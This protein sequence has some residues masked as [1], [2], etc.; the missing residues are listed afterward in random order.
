[1]H[2]ADM[3]LGLFP[4]WFGPPQPDWPAN[5]R[6]VG[7]PLWDAHEAAELPGDVREFLAAGDAPIAFSPGSANRA[8]HQFFEAAV[9]ACQRL[10]RRGTLDDEIRR[11]IAGDAAA[12]SAA[13]R[14]RAAQPVAAPHGGAGPSRRHR[15]LRQGL[16]AG[17]PQL[18]RP[19]A[20]DQ[21]D[22]SRRLAALGVAEE[23][24][25]KAFHGPAIAA[26]LERLLAS[27]RVETEMRGTGRPLQRRGLAR[28]GM[29]CAG[30]FGAGCRGGV[31]SADCSPQSVADRG[32]PAA[33]GAWLGAGGGRGGGDRAGGGLELRD[34][35]RDFGLEAVHGERA[36]VIGE[37][38]G[39]VARL[40]AEPAQRRERPRVVRID[41]ERLDQLRLGLLRLAGFFQQAGELD[42]RLGRIVDWP[43]PNC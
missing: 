6:L 28:R 25:V 1:M 41:R 35:G 9:E 18:V 34:A 19:M 4:D 17:V 10:G 13:L 7:F 5:T 27:P 3:V 26:A 24:S 12:G 31:K 42:L 43:R 20:F 37:R 14:L 2:Q 39:V 32:R 8:A 23:I 33:G 38:L 11:P 16:A 22:N 29:R 36:L 15:Q 30:V 40:V 21:F